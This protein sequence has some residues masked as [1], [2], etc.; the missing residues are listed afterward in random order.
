[1]MAILIVYSD[2][3]NVWNSSCVNYPHNS[4]SFLLL[5]LSFTKGICFPWTWSE[6]FTLPQDS[7]A[8]PATPLLQGCPSLGTKSHRKRVNLFYIIP[9]KHAQMIRLE[10]VPM[11]SFLLHTG[12]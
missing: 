10:L 1:M 8:S 3:M 11:T 9:K 5:R 2:K 12:F 4:W 7:G 6:G